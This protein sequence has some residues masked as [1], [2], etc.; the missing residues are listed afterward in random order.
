[1]WSWRCLHAVCHHYKQFLP[2]AECTCLFPG[3]PVVF[4][5]ILVRKARTYNRE[6]RGTN[7]ALARRVAED[8]KVDQVAAEFVIRDVIIGED[9]SFLM[10]ACALRLLWPRCLQ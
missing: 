4:G 8:L 9:Y 6:T 1:M 5:F 2:T 3:L 7:A 10:D